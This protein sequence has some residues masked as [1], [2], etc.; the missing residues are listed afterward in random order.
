MH[1][2]V[3]IA[4]VFDIFVNRERELRLLDEIIG[5]TGQARINV[6]KATV[7]SG[8]SSALLSVIGKRSADENLIYFDA[9][10]SRP[11]ALFEQTVNWIASRGEKFAAQVLLPLA[12]PNKK[13]SFA[14]LF[15]SGLTAVPLVGDTISTLFDL[16]TDW[17]MATPDTGEYNS[18]IKALFE[19]L[20]RSG[21]VVLIADHFHSA[22]EHHIAQLVNVLYTLENVSL[23]I[24]Q[25][26]PSKSL[27]KQ[28][29][30]RKW[31]VFS[32]RVSEFPDP[33][34]DLA[35]KIL[36][37]I[38]DK[39]NINISEKFAQK[40]AHGLRHFLD[41]VSHFISEMG[42]Y[43]FEMKQIHR[44][45][46][47][48]LR[49][50]D[51]PLT[52]S[53]IF[54]CIVFNNIFIGDLV[55][56]NREIGVLFDAGFVSVNNGWGGSTS[57]LL[58][59]RGGQCADE[60]LTKVARLY[61]ENCLYRTVDQGVAQG[62]IRAETVGLLMYRLASRVDERRTYH[63]SIAMLRSC[64]AASD[65][66]EAERA[67]TRIKTALSDSREEDILHI[68]SAC[69]AT[70][71][72]EDGLGYLGRLSTQT[73]RTKILESILLYRCLRLEQ[74]LAEM[75]ALWRL[76]IE[77]NDAC[78]LATFFVA[79]CIDM[80]TVDQHRGRIDQ[81]LEAFRHCHSY[82]YL[83]NIVAATRGAPEA[84]NLCERSLRFFRLAKD[85]FGQG[86]AIANIG[87]HRIKMGRFKESIR[88]STK[89]HEMLAAFGI[90][91][92]HLVANNLGCAN[93]MLG[94]FQEGLVWLHRCLALAQTPTV[95][96]NAL[97]NL[98]AIHVCLGQVDAAR[99]AIAGAIA[100]ASKNPIGHVKKRTWQNI[101]VLHAIIGL[102]MV[103]V[104]PELQNARKGPEN[105]LTDLEELSERAAKYGALHCIQNYYLPRTNQY[106]YPNPMELFEEKKLSVETHLKNSSD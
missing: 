70:K 30:D 5:D 101:R 88:S 15:A 80:E 71:R 1:A 62:R 56:F 58:S 57:V 73:T 90:Q 23:L 3:Q 28:V 48:I 34:I 49:V 104:A 96:I 60:E 51:E 46:I 44:D 37:F 65:F 99:E 11:E 18:K 102:P 87:V 32:S 25:N 4:D 35:L 10:D 26:T 54:E 13:K 63:W 27:S 55:I 9:L 38:N 40:I 61:Y 81:W 19:Q 29:T 33:D 72:Y 41:E 77:G 95:R 76:G 75:E 7:D 66:F 53:L 20:G 21:R 6:V 22:H 52:L 12:R 59:R 74:S 94:Q 82:G 69:I 42:H 105:D 50:A 86:G 91:H 98:G 78:L 14:R 43:H 2:D 39:H 93:L 92:I 79:L 83:L 68:L 103:E 17:F 67:L 106:W 97:T 84:I 45:I 16:A 100:E 8:L 85:W 36:D 24:G 31:S 64:V 89:A 47:N